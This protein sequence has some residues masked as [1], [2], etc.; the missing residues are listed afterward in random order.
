MV[1]LL[2]PLLLRDIDLKCMRKSEENFICVPFPGHT[3]A[4]QQPYL[5]RGPVS[6]LSARASSCCAQTCCRKQPAHVHPHSP[7]LTTQPAHLKL[8]TE[9][10]LFSREVVNVP[11]FCWPGSHMAEEKWD[12]VWGQGHAL[13]ISPPPVIMAEM[14]GKRLPFTRCW[15]MFVFRLS[16]MLKWGKQLFT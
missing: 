2:S 3:A 5:R 12:R 6:S 13:G 10:E 11:E 9:V 7:L 4:P 14:H 15:H 8:K 1:L 16:P